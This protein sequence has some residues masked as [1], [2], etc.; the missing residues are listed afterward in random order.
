MKPLLEFVWDKVPWYIRFPL[1]FIG[2]TI[3]AYVTVETWVISKANTIVDPLRKE[4]KAVSRR[5]DD[6]IKS[7]DTRIISMDQKLNIL[8]Q[9][10]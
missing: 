10:K 2:I 8:I 4:V 3:G 6:M 7:V 5:Q 1:L 9:R